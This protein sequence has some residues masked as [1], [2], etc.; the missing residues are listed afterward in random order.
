MHIAPIIICN[1]KVR[2][3]THLHHSNTNIFFHYTDV[4]TSFI[5]P[6]LYNRLPATIHQHSI[7]PKST[8]VWSPRLHLAIGAYIMCGVFEEK[9][10]LN[11]ICVQLNKVIELQDQ[12]P[13]FLHFRWEAQARFILENDAWYDRYRAQCHSDFRESWQQFGGDCL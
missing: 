5:T 2:S 12:D 4:R 9:I 6:R 11:I 10:H 7:R 3:L 13:E 8:K 1:G